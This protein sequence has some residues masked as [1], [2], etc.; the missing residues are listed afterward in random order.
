MDDPQVLWKSAAGEEEQEQGAMTENVD[1]LQEGTAAVGLPE[2]SQGT[3]STTYQDVDIKHGQA[4]FDVH[5]PKDVTV[6]G[7]DVK[8]EVSTS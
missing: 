4:K 3:K 6:E 2:A 7:K 5:A 1:N 8:W